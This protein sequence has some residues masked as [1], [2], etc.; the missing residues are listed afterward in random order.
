MA[1][2]RALGK[3]SLQFAPRSEGRQEWARQATDPVDVPLA[4]CYHAPVPLYLSIPMIPA[5]LVL[6]G[7]GLWASGHPRRLLAVLGNVAA[8][9]GVLLSLCGTLL[10]CLPD[11]F[12]G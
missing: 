5:G 6:A 9:V 12:N 8:P 3:A 1:R 7:W 4:L 11:F 10:V 2:A